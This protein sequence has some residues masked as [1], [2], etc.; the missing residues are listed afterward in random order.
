M[1]RTGLA[2]WNHTGQAEQAGQRGEFVKEQSTDRLRVP[3][4]PFSLLSIWGY[5]MQLGD[6]WK[7]VNETVWTTWLGLL[8][9]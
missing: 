6:P 8:G 9:R 5:P 1:A 7:L 2:A 3:P 4:F